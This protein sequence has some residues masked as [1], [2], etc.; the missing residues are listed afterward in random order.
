[1]AVPALLV[2]GLAK[3]GLDVAKESLPKAID[4]F[5]TTRKVDK[6]VLVSF[7]QFFGPTV[8]ELTAALETLSKDQ[9]LVSS[10]AL[11]V[12]KEAI[13][14][15]QAHLACCTSPEERAEVTKHVVQFVNDARTINEAERNFR[16]KMWTGVLGVA[17]VFGGVVVALKYPQVGGT[18]LKRGGRFLGTGRIA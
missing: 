18:L 16:Q 7:I 2:A 17:L 6:E 5:V 1:M 9:A 8:A 11:D 12:V 13:S 4:A 3:A 10:R 15:C 14:Y